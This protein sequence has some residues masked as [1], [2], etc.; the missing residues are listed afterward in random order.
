MNSTP[1]RPLEG[2]HAL[3]TG[4]GSG[5]GRA[6]AVALAEAGA[7]VAL[8]GR[9]P[10]ELESALQEIGGAQAGHFILTAD[11]SS[12]EDMTAAF[13]NTAK[14]WNHLDVVVANAGINGVWAPLEEMEIDEWDTTLAINLRGTFLTVKLALPLLE[15]IR[16]RRQRHCGLLGQRQP[17]VQQLRSQRL[18]HLQSRPSGVRENDRARTRPPPHPGQR[19]LPRSHRDQH[20]RLHRTPRH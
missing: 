15:K 17:H 8:L 19:H 9:T 11:V 7:K 13:Q 16:R 18:R 3:V 4:A 12:A 6:C 20:R 5:I 2:K 10:D 1:H 14:A